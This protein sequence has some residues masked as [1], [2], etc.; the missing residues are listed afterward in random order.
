MQLFD[1][2]LVYP[3][4]NVLLAI[5]QVLFSLGVPAALAVSIVVL[6]IIIRFILYP[7]T[8]SQLKAAKK[9]QD[10]SPHLKKLKD[11]HKSDAKRLQEETMKL[12]KV[13]G[14]NPV[15]GC[16]PLLIQLPVIWGLYSVLNLIVHLKPEETVAKINNIAYF[17]ILKLQ[18]GWDTHIFNI[19]LGQTP[20]QLLQ[21]VGPIVLLVPILTG[22]FQFIQSKMMISAT[23]KDEPKDKKKAEP[24]FQ[25][26]LQTQTLY[27][28]PLM[29][30]F[31]SFNFPLGLSLYWNTFTI[32][33][34]IQQYQIQGWGGLEPYVK[35]VF[36]SQSE[37][38]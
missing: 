24:D 29:I 21:T 12:Y 16:L 37:K 3:I 32:F 4:I 22:V 6:T 1:Q 34:I 26:A 8:A 14:V 28:F 10:L 15:A 2:L 5:Y 30:G 25:S 13:H 19:S 27:V 17:D 33:G 18:A 7:F 23:P 20:A 35:K 38:K 36:Q 31:F 11:K 9:M